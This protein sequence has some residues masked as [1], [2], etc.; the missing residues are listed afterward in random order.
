MS[1]HVCVKYIGVAGPHPDQG[2]P[3]IT[4]DIGGFNGPDDAP[5]LL[6]RWYQSGAFLPVMRVH[7]DI[8]DK[9][10]FPFLY[11]DAAGHAMQNALN[12]RYQLLPYLYS[13][14]HGAYRDGAPVRCLITITHDHHPLCFCLPLIQSLFT[15]VSLSPSLSLF[16]SVSFAFSAS[17]CLYMARSFLPSVPI[18]H[19]SP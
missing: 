16:L 4:C 8:S 19:Y 1:V 2:A 6:A 12:L 14:A 9:P 13:V 3:Y 15:F 5:D 10:H 17:V 11:G 18:L 7:S